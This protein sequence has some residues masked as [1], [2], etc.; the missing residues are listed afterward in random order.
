MNEIKKQEDKIQ[1]LLTK[2]KDLQID[3][4]KNEIVNEYLLNSEDEQKEKK[5]VKQDALQFEETKELRKYYTTLKKDVDKMK[6][7]QR[8]F[9]NKLTKRIETLKKKKAKK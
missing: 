1:Q 2:S 5:K 4:K 9:Q 3:M 8:V 6:H 7:Q